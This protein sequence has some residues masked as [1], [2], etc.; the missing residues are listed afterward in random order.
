MQPLDA[1][2]LKHLA[3]ELNAWLARSKVN[4]IQQPTRFEFILTLWG[5]GL[6]E[7]AGAIAG[8]RLYLCIHPETPCAFLSSA[9]QLRPV[10]KPTLAKPTGFCMLLRKHL[11]NAT[12]QS[13]STIA[14]EQV[15][16][17]H[18]SNVNE[19]GNL[20][21]LIL[22]VELIGKHSNI[23]LID[24]LQGLILGS[25]HI[26]TDEMSRLRQVAA[27]VPY[28]VPPRPQEKR[29]L[30][31]IDQALWMGWLAH[32]AIVPLENIETMLQEH[33]WG[34]RRQQ[35]QALL[36]PYVDATG[37]IE[38]EVAYQRLQDLLLG[39]HLRP[40]VLETQDGCQFQLMAPNTWQSCQSVHDM[41]SRY[42]LASLREIR[43]ENARRRIIQQFE[44][45]YKRCKR[46]IKE[47]HPVS[48]A[49]IQAL[50][51]QGDLL[52]TAL[53]C[54][55]LPD[56]VPPKLTL[57]DPQDDTLWTLDLDPA[58]DWSGNAQRFYRLA[59]KAKVRL[60]V[61]QARL[62]T[63]ENERQYLEDL[64]CLA[65]QADNPDELDAI[66]QDA[67]A[68]GF[69]SGLKPSAGKRSGRPATPEPEAWLSLR[70]S[71][72]IPLLVGK[73]GRANGL[74]V[75]KLAKPHDIWLHVHQ[76]PGSHVLIKT[77]RLPISDQTLL[78]AAM[79]AAHFSTARE[80][81][82]VPVVYTE[83]RYVR[84]IPN[85]YP[86]HVNYRNERALHVTPD[87][88]CLQNLLTSCAN[89]VAIQ[90]LETF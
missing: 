71:D 10:L 81:R 31:E 35:V 83:M 4:R 43:L 16:N 20:A 47:I 17:F 67:S 58:V 78:E 38:T 15:L 50:T 9:D 33:V 70:S 52:Y 40:G 25:A 56:R 30:E 68:A 76:M 42:S 29:L 89:P 8:S 2:T 79:L 12:L 85:S 41:V 13:V 32:Q 61:S 84:K 80:S 11:N 53:S 24:D 26:V 64:L 7:S 74:L 45:R 44:A 57:A 51:H 3:H 39:L 1:I 6:P 21:H 54:G 87:P 36:L 59:R 90:N 72:G 5:R 69:I 49:T 86:G 27:G 60:E 55:S 23:L 14:G 18:F 48:A 28:Q 82:N 22:S 73:S 34:L 63:L 46:Q 62:Q 75:G 66:Q 37:R 19:L 88:G 77:D 65:A